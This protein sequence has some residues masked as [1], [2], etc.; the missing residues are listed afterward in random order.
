MLEREAMAILVS[1][2][3][4][5]MLRAQ[6]LAKS[7]GALALLSDPH[8]CAD[9]LKAEGIRAIQK[10][11][12][13][14][15]RILDGIYDA[16]VH[17][18]A[19]G[20]EGYP[21][22]LAQIPRPPHLLFAQGAAFLDDALPVAVVGTRGAS[23]YGLRHT[24]RIAKELAG[25]GACIASGLAVGIDAAAHEGALAAG[26][27]TVA[28]LGG[29]LDRFFPM[30]NIRLR[31]RILENGGSVV[32]EYP[33]GMPPTRYSFLH[34]NRIIAGLSMGTL[35]M[36]GPVRSG[37]LRTASDAADYGREVF[38]LPGDVDAPG[39][40]LPHKLIAE[41]AH[42]A[43]CA[44]DVLRVLAPQLAMEAGEEKRQAQRRQRSAKP[45]GGNALGQKQPAGQ[46]ATQPDVPDDL[47][48]EE[49]AVLTA[50]MTGEKE[51]DQLSEETGFD[52]AALGAVLMGLEMDGLIDALP[53]LRYARRV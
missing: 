46:E 2:G 35:V 18:I 31:D 49:R 32:S 19:L 53:G 43:T 14:S 1:A 23:E 11:S 9:L 48:K 29:A 28:V 33:M 37:A 26:G 4:P 39:S 7:G 13:E 52:G 22:R 47:P 15:D 24:R 3:I 41:G 50:L 45:T 42:L 6:A 38:A 34:R 21:E 12:R 8:A 30:E 17:L 40:A 10:V 20:E 16:G 27:R 25:A 36:D 5:Y 51:F 44:G